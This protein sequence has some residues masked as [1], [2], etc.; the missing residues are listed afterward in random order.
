MNGNNPYAGAPGTVQAGQPTHGVELSGEE[1]EIL[2]REV[3]AIVSQTQSYLPE[4]YHV[5]SELSF[6]GTTPLATVAVDP[7]AGHP[8]S[9]G[10]TPEV[11]DLKSG[12]NESDTAEVAQGLAASAAMQVMSAVGDSVTPTGR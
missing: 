11:E 7:P 6:D 9:A 1:K 12:L 4:G 3:A 2:R 8:V 5:G 10:F